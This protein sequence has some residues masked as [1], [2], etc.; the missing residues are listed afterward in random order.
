VTFNVVN[1]DG[2][3]VRNV[4]VQLGFFG[5]K[6]IRGTTDENGCFTGEGETGSVSYCL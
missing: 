2:V 4:P 5:G 6:G 3:P 1:Q